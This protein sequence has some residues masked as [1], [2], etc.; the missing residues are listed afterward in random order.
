MIIRVL[1]IERHTL[2]GYR[3]STFVYV[4]NC[5][6]GNWHVEIECVYTDCIAVC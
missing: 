4:K 1:L 5:N 3:D 6:L 2:I